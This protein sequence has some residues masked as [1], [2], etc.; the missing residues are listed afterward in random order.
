MTPSV[1]IL[2]LLAFASGGVWAG[3]MAWFIWV[4]HERRTLQ[5]QARIFDEAARW[6][7]EDVRR[8][9]AAPLLGDDEGWAIFD[10][11]WREVKH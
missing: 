8:K 10:E 3:A 2:L 11:D 9:A 1:L 6:A 7:R 5:I 4:Y